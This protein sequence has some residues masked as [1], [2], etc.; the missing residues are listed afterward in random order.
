MFAQGAPSVYM[1]FTCGCAGARL[2]GGDLTGMHCKQAL[3][4]VFSLFWTDWAY[5]RLRGVGMQI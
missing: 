2:A 3:C 1:G 4:G 5:E